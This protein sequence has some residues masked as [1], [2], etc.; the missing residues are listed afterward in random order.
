M[1]NDQLNLAIGIIAGS[2]SVSVSF[3]VPV[4]N[5]YSS[6]YKILIHEC[7]ATL[8]NELVKAGYSLFMTNKGLSID[9][10]GD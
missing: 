1:T 6:T 4:T 9:K 7:N 3:N 2:N 8:I 10:F 5:N